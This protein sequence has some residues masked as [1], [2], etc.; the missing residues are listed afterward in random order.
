MDTHP[1]GRPRLVA[2]KGPL[3]LR[4]TNTN[5]GASTDVDASGSALVEYRTDG[6]Q[7]WR[8]RGPVPAGWAE[9]GGNMPR[10]LYRLDGVYSL[11]IAASGTKTLSMEHGTAEPLCPLIA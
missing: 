3:V 8:A 6:S 1:D 5:T 9:N 4:I 11:E 2:Y 10:G 7:M